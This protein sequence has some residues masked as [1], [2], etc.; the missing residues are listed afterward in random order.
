MRKKNS[1]SRFVQAVSPWGEKEKNYE[2]GKMINL[3]HL[4]VEQDVTSF[5]T[6]DFEGVPVE[7]TFGTAL[8]ECG[9]GRDELQFIAKY[10]MA[11]NPEKDIIRTVDDLLITLRTDY[12][13]L[14]LLDKLEPTEDLLGIIERLAYQGK[15]LE[16]GGLELE[17]EEIRTVS[18]TL[19]LRANETRPISLSEIKRS[20]D[21]AKVSSGDIT[22]LVWLP[23]ERANGNNS[24]SR[25]LCEKYETDNTGLTLAWI[26]EHP[27]H[28]HPVMNFTTDEEITQ[29]VSSKEIALDPVDWQKIN[30]LLS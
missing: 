26:L 24:I 27:A 20:L 8:S 15:V 3:L 29:T 19:P 16:F 7:R 11:G 9:L 10:R 17:E 21:S 2:K 4:C 23:R 14:L 18:Q 5:Q 6:T 28:V 30:L 13:D 25:E 12:L 1:Y 22:H